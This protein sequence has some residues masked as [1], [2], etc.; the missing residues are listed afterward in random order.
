MGDDFLIFAANVLKDLDLKKYSDE[1]LG[2]V[3]TM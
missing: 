1:I 3:D 2:F